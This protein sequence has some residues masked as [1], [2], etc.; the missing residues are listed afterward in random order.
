MSNCALFRCRHN[1]MCHARHE[2]RLRVSDSR[3]TRTSMLIMEFEY[4]DQMAIFIQ[5]LFI[6]EWTVKAADH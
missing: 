6:N 2:M 5:R 1:V 3:D 4:S